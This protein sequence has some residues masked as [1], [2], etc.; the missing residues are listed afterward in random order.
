[1]AMALCLG[2]GAI[3]V[4]QSP[5]AKDPGP[6]APDRMPLARLTADA[7]I[8]VAAGPGAAVTGD[9]VWVPVPGT[10]SVRRIDAKTNTPGADVRLEHAPCA[11]LVS[12]F[13]SLWV[14]QCEG[15]VT[16]RLDPVKGTVTA[17]A[18]VAPAAATG[19]IAVAVGSVWIAS[20]ARGVVSRI[21]PA[22]NAPVAEIYVG[23]RPVAVAGSDDGLW[24]TSEDGDVVA[25]VNPH[26][27][28]VGETVKVGPR[29]GRLAVGEGAVWVL[30]RGDGSV[31]R[32]DPK[33][34]TVVATI[35]VDAAAGEGD[36][37]AGEGSVWVS[38]PGVPLVRIDPATNRAVQRFDGEGGGVVAV[39]H[40]SIW[41]NAAAA[42]LWRLDPLLVAGTRP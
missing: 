12:A 37:A 3:A 24:V 17:A 35:A 30:N 10:R 11:S 22:T 36:I 16:S 20:D 13:D 2:G 41:L 18:A 23:Q 19:R 33:T 8:A 7:V 25:Q 9:A 4:A 32:I 40:G 5:A 42:T 26:T 21:D 6:R 15:R 14:P 34:A 31:T 38:A 29:P 39:G 28:G 27:N 1:M